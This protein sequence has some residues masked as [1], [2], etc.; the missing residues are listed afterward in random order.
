MAYLSF[1][2]GPEKGRY[3]LL[4]WRSRVALRC[5]ALEEVVNMSISFIISR[6]YQKSKAILQ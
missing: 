3:L 1:N 4:T 6:K 5:G 2:L